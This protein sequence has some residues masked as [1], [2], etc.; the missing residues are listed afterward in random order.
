MA[1]EHP[2]ALRWA[3]LHL[4]EVT[5]VSELA[6]GMTSTMLALDTS[7]GARAVLRLMTKEPWRAH[8]EGLVERESTLQRHLSGG[9]VPAPAS[10]AVDATGDHCGHPAHL[11]TLVAGRT[12]T[13][14]ADDAS[15]VLLSDSLARIHATVPPRGLRAYQSWAWEAKYVV[16]DWTSQPAAWRAAFEVLR[17][18]P[19]PFEPTLIHRDFHLRNVLWSDAA[20]SGVVDWVEASIGPP[21]LDVT[22]CSTNLALDHGVEVGQRFAKLYCDRTGRQ[23][24]PYFDVMDIVGFLPPPGRE[25]FA[26]LSTA[27]GRRRLDEL[28]VR[29]LKRARA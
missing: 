2:S 15:L 28:L 9:E 12:D 7:T 3:E 13:N 25:P 8:G 4:G 6:G 1:I 17:Q 18:D 23:P 26:F 16:P 11:M 22:H 5:A 27:V 14:R 29:S 21:W 20:V 10:L 24:Q 19:P